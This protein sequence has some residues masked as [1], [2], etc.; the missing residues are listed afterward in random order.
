MINR[1]DLP[2]SACAMVR[3]G[4][5]C[6]CGHAL[7]WLIGGIAPGSF[8]SLLLKHRLPAASS[9]LLQL[10]KLAL[11]RVQAPSGSP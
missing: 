8:F 5:K 7:F 11:R 4:V 6:N 9:I 3:T 10:V 1:S 2:S